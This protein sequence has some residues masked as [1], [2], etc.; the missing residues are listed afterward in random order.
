MCHVCL[1]PGLDLREVI[2]PPKTAEEVEKEAQEG[3][4]TYIRSH[5]AYFVGKKN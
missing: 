4:E 2:N 3:H 5:N 1:C